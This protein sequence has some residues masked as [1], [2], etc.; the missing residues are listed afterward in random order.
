MLR[1]VDLLEREGPLG[2]LGKVRD[3]AAEGR[4]S[5]VL[6]AGEPGI[7]KTALV[8][9]FAED[10]ADDSR[11]LWGTCDDLTIPRPLGPFRDL[12][13]AEDLRTA[14]IS[15]T[16]PH[17]IHA[18]LL[19]ELQAT[20]QPTILVVEDIHWADEATIDAITVI[21]RRIATMPA[22]LILTFRAGEIGPEHPLS[23]ARDAIR[24][25][26]SLYIQLSP[27]TRTA[28]AVLAGDY[29]DQVYEVT[30]GNPFYVT[31]LVASEPAGLPPSVASAVLGR[32]SRLEQS[33]RHLVELVSMVPTRIPTGILD[34]VMPE[35]EGAAEEPERRQLLTIDL[36]YA[37]FRHE[38]ARSAIRS[39][40]PAARRRVL[41]AEI[42]S[43]LLTLGADPADIVHHAEEAGDIESVATHALVA[44]RQA[45]AVESNREAYAH[46]LRASQFADRL[47]QPEQAVLFE[48]LAIAAYTVDRLPDAFAA[49]ERAMAINREIGEEMALGRCTR[50][51]SR[52]HWFAGDGEAAIR[53]S[54]AAVA[55][56]EPLGES[57]ELARAYSA[58]SQEAMLAGRIDETLEWG[59]RAVD[60]AARLGDEGVKAHALVNIGSILFQSD[61]TQTATLLEA[62]HLAD[63]IGD[64]HE[65]VRALLNLGYSAL[66]WIQPATARRYTSM[67]IE[68]AEE[69]QVDA[70]LLYARVISA[71]L[72]LREGQWSEAER[73][74]GEVG[75][76]EPSVAQLLAKTV[77]TELAIR[78]GDSDAPERLAELADQ[79]E[80]TAE[81]QRIGPVL[82]LETEWALT[83]GAPMPLE[84]F[85]RAKPIMQTSQGWQESTVAAW[86][87]VAGVPIAFD[88]RAPEPHS[89]MIRHDW[90]AAADLYADV[91]WE[92]DRALML[93]LLA[94]EAALSQAIEIAR[95]L[96]ARPL[97][98]RVSRQM[99]QLGMPVPPVRRRPA[100]T[101]PGGLT[102]RQLEVIELLAKGLTNA[103]IAER[104][105]VSTRTA[106]HHVE[107]ILTKLGVTSRREAAR[108][109]AELSSA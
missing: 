75:Q 63:A 7:G 16:P 14:L 74:A 86:A 97:E 87:A 59:N 21:G 70:L 91:G 29:A 28:V 13:G 108:R 85:E 56:L 49:I 105:Y 104:L 1:L 27:L 6:V 67:A 48:E 102:S 15:E 65:A 82:Q 4:G 92:Y 83:T 3:E 43:A 36:Q 52:C 88:G 20:S 72:Q 101:N 10:H 51:L 80:R 33:S 19:E 39:S 90:A 66:T 103:E 5:V 45:A 98:E 42:L 23:A 81:L 50:F 99:K 60:L 62:H 9:R 17:R 41:N 53:E 64:R 38:L 78:R 37:R 58:L 54:R 22:L 47:S 44:A 31:E 40:V 84:R 24:A 100:V 61:P 69:H 26:T 96:E 109:Y 95:R 35:W 76:R 93:S 18:L 89:E 34:V 107:A 8:T 106:E 2:A 79:A 94:E 77:L 46:Y 30:G 25:N 68:Y 55:I 12:T 11:I 57:V 73:V 32:A 71:W